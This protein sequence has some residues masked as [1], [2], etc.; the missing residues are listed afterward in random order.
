MIKVFLMSTPAVY[1]EEE[2]IFFSYK[3]EEGLFYFL[4]MEQTVTRDQMAGVF[5]ADCSEQTA[6]KNLR[7][8]LYHLRRLLGEDVVRSKGNQ[9]LELNRERVRLKQMY[10]DACKE[11]IRELIRKQDLY[12]IQGQY[13]FLLDNSIY[14]ES[15]YRGIMEIEMRSGRYNEAVQVYQKLKHT[16]CTELDSEPEKETEELYRRIQQMKTQIQRDSGVTDKKRFFCGRNEELHILRQELGGFLENTT[17]RKEAHSVV[18]FRE[19]GVGKT[20]LLQEFEQY[21]SRQQVML[22]HYNCAQSGERLNFRPWYDICMQMQQEGIGADVDFGFMDQLQSPA[23][24]WKIECFSAQLE[25][26]IE[27]IFREAVKKQKRRIMLVFDDIQWMDASSQRLL[28]NLVYHIGRDDLLMVAACRSDSGESV[29]ELTVPL[30]ASNRMI[31]MELS[32][33]SLE[34]RMGFIA[35]SDFAFTVSIQILSMVVI[36]GIG[37]IR[38]PILGGIL[39][40]F[41]PELLRF[42]DNY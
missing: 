14:D 23:R 1:R 15:I 40:T 13:V 18:I 35:S 39:L 11:Y 36:G 26:L 29:K 30:L 9:F 42:A 37:T 24:E 31:T 38:G 22:L 27:N 4:C 28:G 25:Q 8:A 3:K 12:G 41:L 34:E 21:V 7:N 17:Q 33:F 10:V 32:C 2:Q 16:L 19:A 20:C 6:R 5:W